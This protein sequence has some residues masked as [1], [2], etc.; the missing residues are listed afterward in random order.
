MI[1]EKK[2]GLLT[3]KQKRDRRPLIRSSGALSV[4]EFCIICIHLHCIAMVAVLNIWEFRK[5]RFWW[6]LCMFKVTR[7]KLSNGLPSLLSFYI[8]IWG[9]WQGNTA[10]EIPVSAPQTSGSAQQSNNVN[11]GNSNTGHPPQQELSDMLQMLGQSEPTSFEDLSMF[12]TFS[13]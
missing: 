13:E 11:H 8:G 5:T 2:R 1:A 3:S 7:Y 4:I 9:Q 6:G 10:S 12:N